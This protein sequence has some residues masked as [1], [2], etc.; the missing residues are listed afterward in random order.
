M[1][2]HV[3]LEVSLE[4]IMAT[5]AQSIFHLSD[6]EKHNNIE[7]QKLIDIEEKAYKGDRQAIK[8]ILDNKH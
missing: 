7:L 1:Q 6:E 8:K 3:E 4:I 5:I 2:E